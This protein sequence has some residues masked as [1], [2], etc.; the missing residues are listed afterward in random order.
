MNSL[1]VQS[2]G[3]FSL[4]SLQVYETHTHKRKAKKEK[5]KAKVGVSGMVKNSRMIAIE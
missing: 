5:E 3:E 4:H 2:Y 1:I